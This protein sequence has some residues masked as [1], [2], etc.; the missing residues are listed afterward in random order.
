MVNM[1]K[2]LISLFVLAVSVLTQGVL[3]ASA[4]DAR[5][6]IQNALGRLVPNRQLPV[7]LTLT[8][9][10]TDAAGV[11]QPF[12]FTMKGKDRVRFESGTGAALVTT[13]QSRGAGWTESGGKV[14]LLPSYSA[15]RRPG[16]VPFFDL[17]SEAD[18]P[19][20]Q[21]TDKGTFSI[22][23]VVTRR[24][25]LKLPDPTPDIRMFRRALDE[26]IDIYID[27]TTQ[28]VVRSESWMRAD[29]NPDARLQ[30]VWE[31]GDYRTISGLA[32][33]FVIRYTLL[34]PGQKPPQRLYTVTEVSINSG[35]SDSTFIAEER[36]R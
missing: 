22:G 8:G 26:E 4:Q 12:R 3:D 13:T 16:V 34:T 2:R 35:V 5:T 30:T 14:R 25:S 18:T 10:L 24:F 23:G 31:F 21:I 19:N 33:P 29:N 32:I 6:S 7:D 36:A 27:V 9:Q 15:I 1:F 20:L 28:L 17:L 11:V